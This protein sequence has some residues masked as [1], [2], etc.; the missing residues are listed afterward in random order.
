MRD[1]TWHGVSTNDYLWPLCSGQP[2]VKILYGP[3]LPWERSPQAELS[4]LWASH[5]QILHLVPFS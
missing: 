4:Y 5:L 2:S 3:P 1:S